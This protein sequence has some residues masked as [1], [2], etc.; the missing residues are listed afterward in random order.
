M[1]TYFLFPFI[2][3]KY[4]Y[5]GNRNIFENELN[6]FNYSLRLPE[7]TSKFYQFQ[8]EEERDL[9]VAFPEDFV[10]HLQYV[11]IDSFQMDI[12]YQHKER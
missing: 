12:K 4:L 1:K 5:D 10:L 6:S 8:L 7:S 3:G 11:C 2:N 9:P